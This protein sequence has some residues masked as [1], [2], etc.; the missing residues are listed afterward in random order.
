MITYLRVFLFHNF[1]FIL[2]SYKIYNY[3]A[4]V[5]LTP[6]KLKA[7]YVTKKKDFRAEFGHLLVQILLRD[8]TQL[9]LAYAEMSERAAKRRRI[10]RGVGAGSGGG[11]GSG[12]SEE[13]EKKDKSKGNRAATEA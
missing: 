10:A 6:A 2:R 7:A 12:D 11:A 9:V 3:Q 5:V 13:S 8:I 4:A 1:Y